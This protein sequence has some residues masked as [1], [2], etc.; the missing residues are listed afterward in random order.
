[1]YHLSIIMPVQV[2]WLSDYQKDLSRDIGLTEWQAC[3]EKIR[4]WMQNIFLSETEVKRYSGD[5]TLNNH[6]TNI[7][8]FSAVTIE[9]LN[10]HDEIP[11]LI[12]LCGIRPRFRFCKGLCADV[13]S[14]S[15]RGEVPHSERLDWSR[16][17]RHSYI[18]AESPHLALILLGLT[19][20][21][22][23]TDFISNLIKFNSKYK[24]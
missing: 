16:G 17:L 19:R 15:L 21:K 7:C 1:M 13:T 20:R 2:T 22:A 3:S 4:Q 5:S 14:L 8:N 9:A 11:K 24:T 23:T 10:Q 18:P 6:F 12:P